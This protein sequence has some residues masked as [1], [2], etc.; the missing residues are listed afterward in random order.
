M[1]NMQ[2]DKTTLEVNKI[3]LAMNVLIQNWR[4]PSILDTNKLY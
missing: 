3:Y 1:V 4:N 2:L